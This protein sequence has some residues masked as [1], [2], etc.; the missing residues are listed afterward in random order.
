MT[1]YILGFG[2][3]QKRSCTEEIKNTPSLFGYPTGIQP[4]LFQDI[5]DINPLPPLDIY[6]SIYSWFKFTNI[7]L[8]KYN[9]FLQSV[10]PWANLYMPPLHFGHLKT[11]PLLEWQK[12]PEGYRS[13]LE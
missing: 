10:T 12:F 9:G 7:L 5:L 2:S 4:S 8:H 3:F 1:G 11:S 13:F 6:D